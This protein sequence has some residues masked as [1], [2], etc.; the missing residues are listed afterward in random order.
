MEEI[1][2]EETVTIDYEAP[3]PT[4]IE[5]E[6]D[7]E[8]L[9][10]WS[11]DDFIAMDTSMVADG[12]SAS[13]E[14]TTGVELGPIEMAAAETAAEDDFTDADAAAFEIEMAA[15]LADVPLPDEIL[16]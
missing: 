4:Q 9:F 15:L 11:E 10:T 8:A 16:A 1:I 13:D 6:T 5:S 12:P 7:Y 14:S 2:V 3:E